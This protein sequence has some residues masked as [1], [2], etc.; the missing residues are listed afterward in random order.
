M[1]GRTTRRWLHTSTILSFESAPGGKPVKI[2]EEYHASAEALNR[3]VDI[4]IVWTDDLRQHLAYYES[5]RQVMIFRH[6]SFLKRRRD[7]GYDEKFLLEASRTMGLL[8]PYGESTQGRWKRRI[9]RKADPDIEAGIACSVP[10]ELSHYGHWQERLS[11]L[12]TA[13]DTSKP[14]G[15]KQLYWDKRDSSQFYTFWFAVLA[16]V[17]TLLF[18]LVQSVTGVLQVIKS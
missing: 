8:F 10:R 5:S 9:R 2:K 4:R 15:L 3:I 12:Q 11:V 13:L 16:I 17:L 14:R 7:Q 18:G 6:A 1:I